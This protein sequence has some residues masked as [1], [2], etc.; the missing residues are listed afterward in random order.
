MAAGLRPDPLGELKR[1]PRLLAAVP[2]AVE[3]IFSSGALTAVRDALQRWGEGEVTRKLF[4]TVI[5]RDF[6]FTSKGTTL[7]GQI[8]S[9]N[10]CGRF[11][12]R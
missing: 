5:A 7:G 3:S 10:G 9:R 2:M 6:I 8:P 1:S 4:K 11:A 12:A